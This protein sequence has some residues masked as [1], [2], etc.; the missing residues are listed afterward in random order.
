MVM[1]DNFDVRGCLICFDFVAIPTR[2]ADSAVA[3]ALVLLI[4]MSVQARIEALEH[5][6][7]LDFVN[8]IQR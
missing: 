8:Q 7:V 6:L 1:W 3:V 2:R 5:S 4:Q